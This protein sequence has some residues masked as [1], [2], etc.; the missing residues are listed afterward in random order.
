MET[1]LAKYGMATT[2]SL[3]TPLAAH[4]M[5]ISSEKPQTSEEEDYMMNIHYA[6]VVRSIMYY[7]VSSR[8]DLAYRLSVLSRFMV[9]PGKA[10]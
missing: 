4:Y 5:L 8:P 1:I 7:M 2:K 6:D 3:L 10:H 9:D